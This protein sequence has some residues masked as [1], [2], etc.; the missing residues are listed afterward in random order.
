MK[1][2]I[3]LPFYTV[4]EE[5]HLN[6]KTITIAV[7]GLDDLSRKI[8]QCAMARYYTGVFQRNISRR[9]VRRWLDNNMSMSPSDK[10]ISDAFTILELR[11]L[12]L[13]NY[14]KEQEKG[15]NE[16]DSLV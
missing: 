11:R 2:T 13:E 12:A 5:I 8:S 6:G 10:R 16:N 14:K 15:Y 1:K 7:D 9:T 3:S 4:F